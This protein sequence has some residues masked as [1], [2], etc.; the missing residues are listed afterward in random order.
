MIIQVSRAHHHYLIDV[1][2][3]QT[4]VPCH[5]LGSFPGKWGMPAQCHSFQV[6]DSMQNQRTTHF[7]LVYIEIVSLATLMYNFLSCRSKRKPTPSQKD[8]KLQNL[9]R[10]KYSKSHQEIGAHT[11]PLQSSCRTFFHSII[12]YVASV[13]KRRATE[14]RTEYCSLVQEM[15]VLICLEF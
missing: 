14:T 15:V 9:Q 3:E 7:L 8:Y 10:W 12:V 4:P 1:S 2:S 11:V 5:Q 13:C 6:L